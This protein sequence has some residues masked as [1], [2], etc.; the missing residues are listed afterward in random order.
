M[1][2]WF[3]SKNAKKAQHIQIDEYAITI[4]MDLKVKITSCFHI[5]RKGLWKSLKSPR[6]KI[7]SEDRNV[8][9]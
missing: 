8:A 6:D 9:Q 2:S 5:W 3:H 4:N 7:P 1:P